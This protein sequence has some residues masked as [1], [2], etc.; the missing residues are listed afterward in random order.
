VSRPRNFSPWTYWQLRLA[1][2]ERA[3]PC[4]AGD[5]GAYP[6]WRDRARTRLD[7]L[8]GPTPAPVAADPE[9]TG[10]EIRAGVRVE[11][12]V[13][14]VEETMAVPARL[15]VP[16]GRAEP[17]TAVLAVHGHGLDKDLL[18]GIDGGDPQRREA[19]ANANGDYAWQLARAGHVVLAP[20]LRAFGERSDRFLDF[21]AIDDFA[22]DVARGEFDCDWNLVCAIAAGTQPLAQN[23]WDLA[24]SLDVLAAHPLVDPGR[25][26]VVGWS[27]GGTLS[28]LLAATDER[29]R[30]AV[31]SCFFSSW[32][33]A[34]RVPWNLCGSQVLLG[35]LGTLEHAD[36]AALVAP[37]ALLVES[38]TD[39]DLFPVDVA[40]REMAEVRHVYESLGAG[41][42]LVHDV[43]DG[44][45]RFHGGQVAPFLAANL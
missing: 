6:A 2:A 11:R 27:Y 31:V 39:D 34:H 12:I 7:A 36:L 20:D 13:F 45:H 4:P 16:Q 3:D 21:P 37:R 22:V 15:L 40:R 32:Q 35:M 23:L 19:I 8:L 5:P 29:V 38:A 33:A 41:E 30:A 10:E 1:A 24:R 42:R 9:T 14:D 44:P 26:G 18:C 25:L 28:L 43:F 17:G